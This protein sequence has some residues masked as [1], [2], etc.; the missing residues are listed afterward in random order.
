M[1]CA[2]WAPVCPS[3]QRPGTLQWRAK[4]PGTVSA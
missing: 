1:R 3:C 4:Q 2:D